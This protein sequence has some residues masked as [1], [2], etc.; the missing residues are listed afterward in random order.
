MKARPPDAIQIVGVTRVRLAKQ[1]AIDAAFAIAPGKN[2]EWASLGGKHPQA[3]VLL[4][5]QPAHRFRRGVV[6]DQS[7]R[8]RGAAPDALDGER[9]QL[10]L[11][12]PAFDVASLRRALTQVLGPLLVHAVA[13]FG[14]RDLRS[15]TS[16]ELPFPFA[17][18]S[19]GGGEDRR[20]A[21]ARR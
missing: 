12:R 20:L 13:L 15:A 5:E 21:L 2:G 1:L 14:V 19:C 7:R 17:Q 11:E 18:G 10:I 4:R 3:T 6:R 9:S 16:T 8:R